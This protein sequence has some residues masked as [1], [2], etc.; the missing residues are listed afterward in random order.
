MRP[1]TDD[2]LKGII[3]ALFDES[4]RGCILV[5]AAW[6]EDCLDKL[7]RATFKRASG[8]GNKELD[9]LLSYE[10]K[11]P[12]LASSTARVKVA[13]ALGLFN[14]RIGRSLRS[15]LNYRNAAAHWRKG[16]T[17]GAPKDQDAKKQLA[18]FLANV[19]H[20]PGLDEIFKLHKGFTGNWPERSE[21]VFSV[22]RV[23]VTLILINVHHVNKKLSPNPRNQL[24]L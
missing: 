21:F 20:P 14:R 7:L 4:D 3:D 24:R 6:V 10:E 13:E 19:P 2:D 18:E 1:Y 5:G 11:N 22:V 15:L 8:I 12:P 16:L 9:K 17:L 23:A